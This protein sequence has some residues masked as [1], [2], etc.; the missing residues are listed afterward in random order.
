MA[1]TEFQI[2]PLGEWNTSIAGQ[3]KVPDH[4]IP[5]KLEGDLNL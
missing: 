5:R 1:E 4:Q 3:C 2:P